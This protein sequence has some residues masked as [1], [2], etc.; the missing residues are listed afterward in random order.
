MG[1]HSRKTVQTHRN[2]ANSR[3][4][5]VDA[6]ICNQGKWPGFPKSRKKPFEVSRK[7][8]YETTPNMTRFAI[9]Q[10]QASQL[11]ASLRNVHEGL[12]ANLPCPEPRTADFQLMCLSKTGLP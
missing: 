12:V 8:T 5:Q 2:H 4:Q 9:G 10:Y 7:K 1:K 11:G 3:R 6:A